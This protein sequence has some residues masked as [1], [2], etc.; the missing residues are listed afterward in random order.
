VILA[1]AG[2]TPLS[3]EFL[4]TLFGA[5]YQEQFHDTMKAEKLLTVQDLRALLVDQWPRVGL[6]L[7]LE[8]K[9]RRHITLVQGAVH[10]HGH[11]SSGA[12]SLTS[13]RHHRVSQ[14]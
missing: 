8:A 2:D 9:L 5:D 4:A 3:T 12:P 11:A 10:S 6:P 1:V 7:A 14:K 13:H